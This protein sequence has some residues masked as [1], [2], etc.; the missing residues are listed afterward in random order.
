MPG[1]FYWTFGDGSASLDMVQIQTYQ[2]TGVYDVTLEVT[3]ETGCIDSL[4]KTLI[5]AP[6][7]DIVYPNAF[8]PNGDDK[9]DLFIGANAGSV[10]LVSNYELLI[11]DRWGKV[12]FRSQN[13]LDGWNGKL[14]NSGKL[15]PIGVYS[16]LATYDVP[17][18]GQQEKRGVATL[19]R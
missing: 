13:P 7:V 10:N 11:F 6:V 1:D 14:N 4:T 15:L 5:I 12:V 16:Y 17:I 3:D 8:T 2:D 18:F 9:N 19:V